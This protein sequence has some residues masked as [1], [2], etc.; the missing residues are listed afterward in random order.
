LRTTDDRLLA[1][2]ESLKSALEVDIAGHEPEWAERARVALIHIENTLRQHIAEVEAPAGLLA[3]EVDLTRPSL[4]REV[5]KLRREHQ[6]LL[7]K[8]AALREQVEAAGQAFQPIIEGASAACAL[9]EPAQHAGVINLGQLR[10]SIEQFLAA[11]L[12][13]REREADLT[14]ESV[15]TDLGAGD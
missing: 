14:L 9:P 11:L 5:S 12:K 7:E 8:A 1:S 6:D 4:V 2:G 15:T 13:H 3:T 10:D